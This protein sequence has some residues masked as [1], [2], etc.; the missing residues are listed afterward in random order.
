[1][2]L[3]GAT[4]T[5]ESKMEI[6]YIYIDENGLT[7][8]RLKPQKTVEEYRSHSGGLFDDDT[9]ESIEDLTGE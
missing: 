9:L 5:K 2:G 1:V 6:D 8:T 7:V 3:S 4:T